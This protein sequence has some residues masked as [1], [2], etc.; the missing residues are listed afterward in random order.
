MVV[1]M[2]H[3]ILKDR[4]GGIKDIFIHSLNGYHCYFTRRSQWK[5][6]IT[7]V[8]RSTWPFILILLLNDI[9]FKLISSLIK[10]QNSTRR[11]C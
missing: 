4:L 6:Y 7:L 11:T 3:V 5:S 2:V 9:Y 8:A 10:V 1:G